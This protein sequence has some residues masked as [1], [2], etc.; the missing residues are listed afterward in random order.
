MAATRLEFAH[1]RSLVFF[2][3]FLCNR[4]SLSTAVAFPSQFSHFIIPQLTAGLLI[5]LEIL[6]ECSSLL[7]SLAAPPCVVRPRRLST[8][9][10]LGLAQV[11]FHIP[12][13]L[14]RLCVLVGLTPWN[15]SGI[16]PQ[17]SFN[18]SSE[19]T[20]LNSNLLESS[21][22]VLHPSLQC[23]ITT[24][25]HQLPPCNAFDAAAVLMGF[26]SISVSLLI[27]WQRFATIERLN[28]QAALNG[29]KEVNA[30]VYLD[31]D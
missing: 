27:L 4:Q 18:L 13:L 5:I 17:S 23:N 8:R 14:A 24:H 29:D 22:S 6:K 1:L 30:G 21:I 26:P 16:S 7:W 11:C 3:L 12:S 19:L 28:L 31:F 10:V 15:A 20:F 2:F 25:I 9:T